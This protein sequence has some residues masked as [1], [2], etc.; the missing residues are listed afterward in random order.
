MPISSNLVVITTLIIAVILLILVSIV[1]SN[2]N[3]LSGKYNSTGKNN[4]DLKNDCG[5]D[6]NG[7]SSTRNIVIIMLVS[8]IFI[9]LSSI[10]ILFIMHKEKLPAFSFNVKKEK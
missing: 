4:K 3:K 7:V 8:T 6:R 1:L 9:I 2:I 10:S 5:L